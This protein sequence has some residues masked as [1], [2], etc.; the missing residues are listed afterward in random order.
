MTS[1]PGPDDASPNGRDGPEGFSAVLF[2]PFKVRQ[3]LDEVHAAPE[4]EAS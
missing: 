4:A 1:T 2:K 3:L